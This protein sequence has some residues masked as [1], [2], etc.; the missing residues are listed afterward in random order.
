MRFI[1]LKMSLFY[2][3]L[4]GRNLSFMIIGTEELNVDEV[5]QDHNK[6]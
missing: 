1:D 6:S 2:Y 4:V 3:V 5:I